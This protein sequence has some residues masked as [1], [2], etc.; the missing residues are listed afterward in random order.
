MSAPTKAK[1][2]EK[3]H[4]VADKIGYPDKWRDYSTLE[5]K[6]GDALGNSLRSRAF[7]VNYQLSKIGKP[8]NREEWGISPPTVNATTTR[9]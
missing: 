7:E 1:A 5:I 8:V 4:L 9:A 2:K 3:L 6:S